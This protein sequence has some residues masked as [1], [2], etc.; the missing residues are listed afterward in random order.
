MPPDPRPDPDRADAPEPAGSGPQPAPGSGGA[1]WSDEEDSASYLGE[2]MV[3]VVAG[4]DLTADDISGA[5]FAQG[6]TAD[7]L[8]PGPQLAALIH[9]ATTDAKILATVSDDELIGVLRGVRRLES[10]A[11]WA[12]LATLA[13]FAAR[14]T[15]PPPD[16]DPDPDPGVP[17]P[18][19][20][21]PAPEPVVSVP[22]VTCRGI[23][24][25]G[26]PVRGIPGWVRGVCACGVWGPA[27][28]D[29]R[30]RG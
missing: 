21:F 28:P 30:V 10:L 19:R 6:G 3:A 17:V 22:G 14:R 8:C 2:L 25:C 20:G 9:A 7:Q 13:E 27:G 12:Q 5:G 23:P 26:I 4:E 11:A 15:D 24:G 1:W 16:P 18:V 29:E